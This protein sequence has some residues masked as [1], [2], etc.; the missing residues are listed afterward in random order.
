[1]SNQAKRQL[2]K[3]YAIVLT[4]AILVA[5]LF[6]MGGCLY[7]YLTQPFTPEA[8]D[9]V[10][11]K[12]V[13]AIYLCLG[14]IVGSFFL[15]AAEKKCPARQKITSPCP[16]NKK[17]VS[18][19]RGTFLVLGVVCVTLGICFDGVQAVVANAIALCMSCIGLG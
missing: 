12:I 11:S 15:P 1:M 7:I 16:Q 14:L 13:W 2:R 9:A 4:C 17:K 19:L 10:F 5:G 3:I 8:V 18:I 6:L